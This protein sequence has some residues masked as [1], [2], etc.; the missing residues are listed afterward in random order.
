MASS[1]RKPVR[2][3]ASDRTAFARADEA[4]LGPMRGLE[5]QLDRLIDE[6]S[7]RNSSVPER[8]PPRREPL[9]VLLERANEADDVDPFGLDP[10]YDTKTRGVLELVYT[11]YFR[12]RV[13]AVDRIPSAGRCL[14]VADRG[15]PL[16]GLLLKMAVKLEHRAP[17]DVRWLSDDLAPLFGAAMSRLGAV[18]ACRENAERL[19]LREALVASFAKIDTSVELALKMRAPIVPVAVFRAGRADIHVGEP[20]ADGGSLGEVVD[21]VR[22]GLRSLAGKR[23]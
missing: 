21:R 6:A 10:A 2:E 3:I 12:V 20:I 8:A 4:G 16:D 22:A 23:A 11:R 13:H 9:P 17:R 18:R 19:L 5:A 15:R 14:I 7:A 1:K